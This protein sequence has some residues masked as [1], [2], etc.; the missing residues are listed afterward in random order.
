MSA[1]ELIEKLM[2]ARNKTTERLHDISFNA[3]L[4]TAASIVRKHFAEME[5]L[6]DQPSAEIFRT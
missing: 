4:Y 2:A 3:G 5:K 1:D 6:E